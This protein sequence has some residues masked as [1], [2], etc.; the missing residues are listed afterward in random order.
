[1]LIGI[2]SKKAMVSQM[3]II[4]L[5]LDGVM[6]TARFRR[7]KGPDLYKEIVDHQNFFHLKKIVDATDKEVSLCIKRLCFFGAPT[8]S[9]CALR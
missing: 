7:A 4:F 1:M 9:A 2:N 5:D 8:G 3:K 6:N